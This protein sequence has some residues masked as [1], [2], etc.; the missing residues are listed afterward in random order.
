MATQRRVKMH[1][2]RETY[3]NSQLNHAKH[4]SPH[5]PNCRCFAKL[6]S[7]HWR[8]QCRLW[9]QT[10]RNTLT[11]LHTNILID[12][13]VR[14]PIVGIGENVRHS[15]ILPLVLAMFAETLPCDH[16]RYRRFGNKI[17][18]EGSKQDTA[19]VNIMQNSTPRTDLPLECVA[20]SGPK[21]YESRFKEVNL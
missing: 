20:A 11:N 18:T 9:V 13:S 8:I 2:F 16:N 12:L 19:T 15:N 7:T 1:L 6:P 14:Q 4:I 3:P 10:D 21:D 5:L 17:V